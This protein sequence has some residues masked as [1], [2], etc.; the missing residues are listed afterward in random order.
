MQQSNT[1]T[2]V[3]TEIQFQK[4]K[5]F[6]IN[7]RLI[8]EATGTSN[9]NIHK[10][11]WKPSLTYFTNQHYTTQ[12][13][14]VIYYINTTCMQFLNECLFRLSSQLWTFISDIPY[15]LF[16]CRQND[17]N[18]ITGL[19]I[20]ILHN[21]TIV[22]PLTTILGKIHTCN[23]NLKTD[24]WSL[25]SYYATSSCIVIIFCKTTVE[26]FLFFSRI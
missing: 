11:Y 9:G 25:I 13:L 10:L 17:I 1:N 23:T 4:S 26:T 12:E 18:C 6:Y 3:R 16:T 2:H 15:S 7:R 22:F 8:Q 14:S 20:L 21:V 24:V 19:T 5:Y